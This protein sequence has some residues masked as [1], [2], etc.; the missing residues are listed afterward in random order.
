[1]DYGLYIL[2]GLSFVWVLYRQTMPVKGLRKLSA[3][4]FKDEL[5]EGMLIDVRESYEYARGHIPGA[6]NIPLRHLERKLAELPDKDQ[7]IYLYCRGGMRSRQA[8]KLL[9]RNGYTRLAYLSGGIMAYEGPINHKRQN[10][11]NG[12][13]NDSDVHDGIFNHRD[14]KSFNQHN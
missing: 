7:P 4:Q 1:M 14:T 5:S 2:L 6:V 12:G 11:R 9:S 13:D 8:G 10:D 3:K